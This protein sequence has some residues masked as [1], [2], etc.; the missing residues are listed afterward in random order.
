MWS[1]QSHGCLHFLWSLKAKAPVPT[2]F[3]AWPG[4][5][6]QCLAQKK[7]RWL[8]PIPLFGRGLEGR[9]KETPARKQINLA[10][11]ILPSGPPRMLMAEK[12]SLPVVCVRVKAFWSYTLS[13]SNIYMTLNYSIHSIILKQ[14][15]HLCALIPCLSHVSER[16]QK[17]HALCPI[18]K[19]ARWKN[20]PNRILSCARE[21]VRL[22]LL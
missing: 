5:C 13:A 20:F 19:C 3:S 6:E 17:R 16:R 21:A 15:R 1:V 8:V 14:K 22:W 10:G 18:A 11:S 9:A 4:G 2:L 12:P 7:K